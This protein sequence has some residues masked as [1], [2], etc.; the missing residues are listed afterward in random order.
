MEQCVKLYNEAEWLEDE[1]DSIQVDNYSQTSVNNYNKKI[2]QLSQMTNIFN[3]N[4]AGKQSE[5]AYKAA[6]K[7]NNQN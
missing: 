3:K 6:R 1:I 2:N 7:L 4:C 5:S